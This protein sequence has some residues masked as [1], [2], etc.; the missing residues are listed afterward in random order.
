MC[1]RKVEKVSWT[2]RAKKEVLHRVKEERHI[3]GKMKR[4]S[5]NWIG[6]IV[7]WNCLLRHVVEGK[8]GEKKEI[9]GRR[10]IRRK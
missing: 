3:I 8:V 10:V 6:H 5:A 9:T 2:N 7:R 4:K 1:W